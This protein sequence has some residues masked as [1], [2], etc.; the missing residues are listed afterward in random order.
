M[1][2]TNVTPVFSKLRS[3]LEQQDTV[4]EA[5][6]SRR[7]AT[8]SKLRIALRHVATFHTASNL[9]E[10][11]RAVRTLL[12]EVGPLVA[13]IEAALP[14]EQGSFHR[15]VD[16]WH[17]QLSSSSM[18]AVLVAFFEEGTLIDAKKVPVV[19]GADV[20]IPLEDFLMG[21]CNALTEMVR[22]STNRVVIADYITPVRCARFAADVFEAFKE[23]NFRNDF[24]R[25]RYDG[26]KYDVKRLEEIVYDLSIRGLVSKETN[27]KDSDA[28]AKEET[29]LD[30]DGEVMKE[31]P[32]AMDT[33]GNAAKT[34]PAAMD[35]VVKADDPDVK[36]DAAE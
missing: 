27:A 33:D 26:V 34:E 32:S 36:G 29:M 15:Y 31:A 8:E 11:A 35:T 17:N 30:S 2:T 12:S 5:L 3:E 6:R 22:I 25:K 4:R 7:D 13:E 19:L 23:L 18:V 24:L 9:V 10:A 1:T 28:G 21:V 20:R 14:S 16:L